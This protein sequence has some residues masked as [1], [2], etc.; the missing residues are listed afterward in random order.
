MT[1]TDNQRGTP[2]AGDV[3]VFAG[4]FPA[5]R[6]SVRVI[7]HQV[8]EFAAASGGDA[9]KVRDV[10]FAVTEAAANVVIHAYDADEA[11]LITVSAD[12]EGGFLEVVVV[13][14]GRGLGA[15]RR[16]GEGLGL[17]MMAGVSDEMTISPHQPRGTEVRMRFVWPARVSTV[18]GPASRA[19]TATNG[20]QGP[21]VGGIGSDR[22]GARFRARL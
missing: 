14:N 7:R 17:K 22:E 5:T 9:H 20:A 4:E 8:T 18:P 21:R 12:V 10:A 3:P 11:G 6:D 15:S 2:A 1:T 19:T 16:T 13:D